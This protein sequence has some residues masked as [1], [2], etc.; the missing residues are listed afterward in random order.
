VFLRAVSEAFRKSTAIN[1]NIADVKWWASRS[2]G[3]L[4]YSSET[5]S[6]VQLLSSVILKFANPTPWP[7]FTL[8]IGNTPA[9]GTAPHYVSSSSPT[10][11][12]HSFCLLF[13]TQLNSIGLSVPLRK[14]ITSPL[15][16]Q[17]VNV[18]YRSTTMV[19]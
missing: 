12:Y 11:H 6:K 8:L 19:H 14:Y 3:K 1:F 18:I 17:Q 5:C 2:T 7:E 16:A 15:R 13:K 10:E 4:T 9:S